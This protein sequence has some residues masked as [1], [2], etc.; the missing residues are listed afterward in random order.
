MVSTYRPYPWPWVQP[1]ILTTTAEEERSQRNY[2][3]D[4]DLE[5]SDDADSDYVPSQGSES[6]AS[7]TDDSTDDSETQTSDT[8]SDDDISLS[9]LEYIRTDAQTARMVSSPTESLREL[10]EQ[11]ILDRQIVDLVKAEEDVRN[12]YNPDEVVLLIIE[13]YELLV[14]M[15]HWPQGSVRYPPHSNSP[16]DEKL[17][18]QLGYDPAAI[19]LMHQLPYL[20]PDAIGNDEE[21][22]IVARTRFADYTLES[23]LREGRRPYPYMYHDK[24]PDLDP[25]LL[26][27]M[28]PDRDGSHVILD[29]RLG[30][31]RAYGTERG[32]PRDT[33]EWRRHGKVSDAEQDQA[34]WTEYRRATLVPAAR[35][36]SEVI[37]AY[38]SLSRLP[39]IHP[40]RNDP[41]EE[42]RP[43]YYVWLA[44]KE[45]EE[46]ETLLTLYRECGWPEAWRRAEFIERWEV[47][48]EEIDNRARQAMLQDGGKRKRNR[49]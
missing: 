44:E 20:T 48:K 17:A 24:D 13:F 26:P 47:R 29:T 6:D 39:I 45:R 40:D 36:F 22:R 38:R 11:E 1:S 9:E 43:S 15:G 49:G 28:L 33:V 10:D 7:D 46:Q 14:T 12:A 2:W 23:D 16:V 31:V 27:L 18:V 4:A 42:R 32:P 25:W 37:H 41:K 5:E 8:T 21:G 35:Y 3:L 19:L 34:M 30:V